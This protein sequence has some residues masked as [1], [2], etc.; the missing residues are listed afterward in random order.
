MT[1]SHA[2]PGVH[3][4]IEQ[5]GSH[6]VSWVF[7]VIGTRQFPAFF[8]PAGLGTGTLMATKTSGNMPPAHYG[9][10]LSNYPTSIGIIIH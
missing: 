2:G 1:I 10:D 7:L 3:R 8:A 6:V 4:I 9:T 5:R